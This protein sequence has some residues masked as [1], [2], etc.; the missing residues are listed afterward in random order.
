M[1]KNT[2]Q[3]PVALLLNQRGLDS[4]ATNE[5]LYKKAYFDLGLD[6]PNF[7]FSVVPQHFPR[8]INRYYNS[9][10]RALIKQLL[11]DGYH[12][13]DIILILQKLGQYK[14]GLIAGKN[15]EEL[16]RLNEIIKSNQSL[17][18]TLGL[19]SNR[20]KKTKF[21]FPVVHWHGLHNQYH[22]WLT[23]SLEG[24]FG[25]SITDGSKAID[26]VKKAMLWTVSFTFIDFILS[27]VI[28]ILLGYFLVMYPDSK[29]NK[30]LSH[31]LYF[32]YSIP[33]FWLATMLVVYF[34]TDDYGVWTNVFPSVGMDVY[35]GKSN[36]EHIVLNA[37]KLILPIFC[38]TIHSLA[39]ITRIVQR[40]LNDE[41]EKEYTHLAFSKGL[42]KKEVIRKHAFKNALI[43]IITLFVGAFA[44]AFSGSL[45]LE[46]IFN[47]PGMGRLLFYAIGAADWNVVF[48]ILM[49]LSLIT[50]V[51]YLIGDILYGYVSPKIRYQQKH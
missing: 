5:A 7:Y 21:Y 46:V 18:E 10:D 3:D 13:D 44:A 37:K 32:I 50:V 43:P 17:I 41:L 4:D 24:G 36:F 47:I 33:I 35:P 48:C 15:S 25:I 1:S 20:F 34:T 31:L 23:S 40:S 45:V 12:S 51:A 29:T 28:G 49:I 9:D 8:N 14:S 19:A 30:I 22:R 26:K 16:T 6:N 38:L 42:S 39:Y 11:R 27:V 2:P